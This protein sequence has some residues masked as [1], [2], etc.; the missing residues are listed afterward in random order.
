[1]RW[2]DPRSELRELHSRPC[3]RL[4]KFWHVCES[5]PCHVFNSI[6]SRFTSNATRKI[7]PTWRDSIHSQ[8]RRSRS[9]LSFIFTM[10]GRKRRVRPPAPHESRQSAIC[11]RQSDRSCTW[12]KRGRCRPG[13][14]T[15]GRSSR[16]EC[17][18]RRLRRWTLVW[19]AIPDGLFLH[20]TRYSN[21]RH[22]AWHGWVG[23][24]WAS[25]LPSLMFALRL[26]MQVRTHCFRHRLHRP[27]AH[28]AT[29]IF[30]RRNSWKV[31]RNSMW[32]VPWRSSNT[33]ITLLRS[34]SLV[35]SSS[36]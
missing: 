6:P 3:S 8:R 36:R 32:Y 13:N 15:K 25:T 30:L 4:T 10:V 35:P 1:M 28:S 24:L 20:R 29:G 2:A 19:G 27:A 23:R 9:L 31:M 5:H 34:L 14:G 26:C 17:F 7:H 11:S 16:H 18:G 22:R 21:I 12:R 33:S